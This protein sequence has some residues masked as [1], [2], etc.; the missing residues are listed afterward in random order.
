MTVLYEKWIGE[1]EVCHYGTNFK[2][3]PLPFSDWYHF[4]EAFS[5]E[6]VANAIDQH[7]SKVD[8]CIDPFGGSGTTALTC[9]MFNVEN[10]S[11]EVNPFLR[12]VI[13]AKTTQ[14]DI[15]ALKTSID[16]FIDQLALAK[17]Q[18]SHV[19]FESLPKTF[20]EPGVKQKWLFNTNVSCILANALDAI[21][22]ENDPSL[23]RLLKV[24]LGSCLISISNVIVN[25]KGRRYRRNW[26]TRQLS[27]Q[28][29]INSISKQLNKY[30][31][32]IINFADRPFGKTN[33]I[34]GDSREKI[35]EIPHFDISIFSPPYPNSFD[36]TDVYNVE[37]WILGY[38]KNSSDNR[39]LRMST[40][41]SHV[42]I[43]RAFKPPPSNSKTLNA[44]L[45][46]LH[47]SR[48]ILWNK[49]I[50][51]MIGSYFHEII[52]TLEKLKKKMNPDGRIHMVVGNSQYANIAIE[53]SIIIAELSPE[54][55][56]RVIQNSNTRFMR[57]SPQQGGRAKLTENILVLG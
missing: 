51:E 25:G 34:L 26:E 39:A 22:E 55:G 37:L 33:I 36:Y 10:H 17:H 19:R 48:D 52:S 8:I 13:I 12:D 3:T 20:I 24:A 28:E 1:R 15:A 5:P 35:D 29:V 54:I 2:S 56:L 31:E 30:Y 14:Y 41:S 4:K 43:S 6:F 38:L 21:D 45:R 49:N 46:E 47:Q 44:A 32:D 11:I 7:P 57:N 40:L 9:Q 50:P 18:A 27:N 53:T 42:Q 23:Q 16:K